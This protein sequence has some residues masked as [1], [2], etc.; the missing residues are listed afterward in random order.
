VNCFALTKLLQDTVN[1]Y[2]YDA[3]HA[4]GTVMTYLWLIT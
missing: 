2:R 4:T 3:G 1:S